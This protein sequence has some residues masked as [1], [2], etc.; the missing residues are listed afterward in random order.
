MPVATGDWYI[1]DEGVNTAVGRQ[2]EQRATNHNGVSIGLALDKLVE[3]NRSGVDDGIAFPVEIYGARGIFAGSCK[4]PLI[5]EQGSVEDAALAVSSSTT[6]TCV[7]MPGKARVSQ[8]S[9]DASAFP[10]SVSAAPQ[11]DALPE[12]QASGGV[13]QA[14]VVSSSTAAA[15]FA[16]PGK[17][18][19]SQGSPDASAFPSSVSAAPQAGALPEA[20]A[21]GGV[22]QATETTTAGAAAADLAADM[23]RQARRDRHTRASSWERRH[24]S[25]LR[26]R[27]WCEDQKSEH[28]YRLRTAH[29]AITRLE[30][31][32]AAEQAAI[33]TAAAQRRAVDLQLA[34]DATA[35]V[36]EV[37]AVLNHE[38]VGIDGG[39]TRCRGS[40]KTLTSTPSTPML[41]WH[42][43]AM[44]SVVAER[45]QPSE[46][47]AVAARVSLATTAI[48]FAERLFGAAPLWDACVSG[49]ELEAT[50]M[51]QRFSLH[52]PVF[53]DA[54]V[55]NSGSFKLDA[56]AI[57]R[58]LHWHP[59]AALIANGARFGFS[60]MSDGAVRRQEWPNPRVTADEAAQV[61]AWIEKQKA[62]GRTVEI[63]E[64]EFEQLVGV[65]V[66][67]VALAPKAGG[68]EG[69]KRICHDM[70]AG[71]SKSVNSGIDFDP[72]NPI[73]L[74]QLES[75]VARIQFMRAQH[76]TRKIMASKCDLKEFFRQIPLRRRDMAR[77]VQRWDGVVY[78]HEAFTF[79]SSSAP[80]ICSVVTNA[81]CDELARRGIYCQCFID[82]CVLLAYGDEI[83]AAVEV[84]RKLIK[85]FGLLENEAKFVPPTQQLAVVGV[86]F[87]LALFTVGVAPDKRAKTLLRLAAL[88]EGTKT[89]VGQLREIAGKLAFLSTVV[90][91]ARCYTA[92][93][94]KAA[95]DA[96][97]PAWQL[98]TINKNIAGAVRWWQGVLKG[99]R[100]SVTD[101]TLGS[102]DRPL[103]IS[104]A[105]TSDACHLGFAGVDMVHK[106]WMQDGWWQGE[107]VDD[108]QI[109]IRECFGTLCWIA[110][111]A[112][113]GVLS[114]TIV[115]F[116]T[117]NECSVWGVNKGHSNTHVLNFLV[118]AMHVLQE[119]YRFLLVLKH[120]PGILNVL[121]DR[122]S[123]NHSADSLGLTPS[124]GWTRL[125]IP[126]SVRKLLAS[127]LTS[128]SSGHVL[129][130]CSARPA[131]VWRSLEDSVL[132]SMRPPP[133]QVAGLSIPWIP[134]LGCSFAPT[135]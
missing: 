64:E 38:R 94:S 128:S 68:A 80:H 30:G 7:T 34:I 62:N 49:S 126:S 61:T 59:H 82:D 118:V 36:A 48:P 89:T 21:S 11:A 74:L 4:P 133:Q 83:D 88:V 91:F 22:Q 90:P 112:E 2:A 122:L 46:V 28:H 79:G 103:F 131:P 100:F 55:V 135:S 17:A 107:V 129:D 63:P 45:V 84:L 44:A 110:A 20:Q 76:P 97:R 116:E 26:R 93:F 69:E 15:C 40:A 3:R 101:L 114:G 47:A 56:E 73:G 10:S 12:A 32:L 27:T 37:P 9:T 6:A 111:L 70:S 119:R 105:I 78:A 120:I 71:G 85:E 1:D 98:V 66:S 108:A 58:I 24:G 19:V 33:E 53:A 86:Q 117:D 16:M 127:A 65:F 51:S 60:L 29:A 50:S 134:Y 92:F 18:P 102:I 124:T 121:S 104:S 14:F 125:L 23:A 13:Q 95:G 41:L 54:S 75:V 87:D 67:P 52:T 113:T 132:E 35:F 96:L 72:L 123:R 8:G 77:V 99:E 81:L 43:K 115:I 42:A 5:E 31:E 130:V 25:V 109:N 39:S 57:A 106:F